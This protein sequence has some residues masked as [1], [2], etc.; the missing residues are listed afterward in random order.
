MLINNLSQNNKNKNNLI[1]EFSPL[2]EEN[3]EEEGHID[4]WEYY[5]KLC[6]SQSPPICALNQIHNICNGTEYTLSLRHFK[7]GKQIQIILNVLQKV[8]TT[9]EL[10]LRD[11]ALDKTCANSLL[12]FIRNSDSLSNLNIADNP[13][14]GSKALIL[15]LSEIGINR[16]LETLDI[17]NTGCYGI[18]KAVSNLI[19]SSYLLQDLN[20]S[21][22]GLKNTAIDIC[23]AIPNGQKLNSLNLSN[24]QLYFGN[25]KFTQSFSLN[26]S[27]SLTL[28]NINLSKNSLTSELVIQLFKNLSDSQVKNINLSQNLI[29]ND[30][31]IAINTF[32]LKSNKIKHLNLSENP[33]LNILLIKKKILNN[34]KIQ[35]KTKEKSSKIAQPGFYLILNSL[36]KSTSM[37]DIT[38]YGIVDNL[39][40]LEEKL[41]IL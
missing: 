14:L 33:L 37:R 16:S 3:N 28:Q 12:D 23:P 34:I 2:E 7:L 1:F 32:I 13:N 17:S 10:D 24:N 29:E 22:C 6:Y 8:K 20:L 11:N 41:N 21:N 39:K 31:C 18:G 38:V 40:E 26:V 9:S 15:I 30:A 19:S 5:K 35:E 25:K 4:L 36:S 27:K